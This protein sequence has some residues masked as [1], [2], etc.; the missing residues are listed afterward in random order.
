M[1]RRKKKAY[2]FIHSSISRNTSKRTSPYIEFW[3]Y[4]LKGSEDFTQELS[5]HLMT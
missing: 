3:L 1:D 2:A 5:V 4:G